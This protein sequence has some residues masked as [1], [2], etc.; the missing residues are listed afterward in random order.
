MHEE[1]RN[2]ELPRSFKTVLN[3]FSNFLL[4]TDIRDRD[5]RFLLRGARG[6]EAGIIAIAILTR[7]FAHGAPAEVG[8]YGMLSLGG[9]IEGMHSFGKSVVN[10]DP[11]KKT[12]INN[13]L[14]RFYE[15][16]QFE[17]LMQTMHDNPTTW[18]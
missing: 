10:F 6:A 18:E 15:S 4:D 17:D 13:L 1:E 11:N 9:F 5:T 14:G 3:S 16:K 8:S 12:F 7:I 2:E